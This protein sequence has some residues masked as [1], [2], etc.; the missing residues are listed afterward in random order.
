M[1]LMI[2][3][4]V[5]FQLGWFACVLG[6]ANADYAWLGSLIVVAIIVVHLIRALRPADELMLVIACSLIGTF[7]DSALTLAGL[8]QFNAGVLINGMA[9]HW[10]IAMWALFATTLNVSM[11]WMHERYLLAAVFGGLGGPLAYFAGHKL[12]AV[13]FNPP[14]ITLVIIGIGWSLIMPL[15]VYLT[16]FFNGYQSVPAN[17]LKA[18]I[19]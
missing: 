16:R 19:S 5:L 15:L 1:S 2:Q 9:P 13:D 11:K 17:A 3:N 14:L 18:E 12:G 4:F 7:W 6:G 8:Y 10:L